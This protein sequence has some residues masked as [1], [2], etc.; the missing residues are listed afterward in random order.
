MFL[1]I[2]YVQTQQHQRPT[3]SFDLFLDLKTPYLSFS[4]SEPVE[5]TGLPIAAQLGPIL[6]HSRKQMIV[7]GCCLPAVESWRLV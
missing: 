7:F 2:F 5:K 3:L 1:Y 6:V 4:F